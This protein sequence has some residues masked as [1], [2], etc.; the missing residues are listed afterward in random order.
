MNVQGINYSI[1]ITIVTYTWV[2]LV[3]RK[4]KLARQVNHYIISS[5]QLIKLIHSRIH[6]ELRNLMIF[7]AR[8]FYLASIPCPKLIKS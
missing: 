6:Y 1:G 7:L 5:H 2:V 3:H 4:I 8:M